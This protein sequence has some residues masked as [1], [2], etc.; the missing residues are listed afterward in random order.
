MGEAGELTLHPQELAGVL[1]CLFFA[2]GDVHLLQI[3]AVLRPRLI[4][5]LTRDLIVELPDV[6]GRFN[7]GV[8][9]DIGIALL[10]R[11][12]DRLLAQHARNPHPRIGLLQW[13][14]PWIDDAMLVMRALPAEWSLPGPRGDNQIVRLLEALT[15]V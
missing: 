4:A 2:V 9:R 15:V 12:N 8:E 7:R 1:L 13:H 11:P 3:A 5:D 10:G 14:R 6:L